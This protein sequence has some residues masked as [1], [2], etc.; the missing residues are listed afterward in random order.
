MPERYFELDVATEAYIHSYKKTR[1]VITIQ[2]GKYAAHITEHYDNDETVIVFCTW[3][4][5]I[6]LPPVVVGTYY[7]KTPLMQKMRLIEVK[8]EKKD[9]FVECG[10][11]KEK[12]GMSF[13]EFGK[14]TFVPANKMN[15]VYR[16][17]LCKEVA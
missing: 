11:C 7:G 9:L 10:F 17:E 15:Y 2:P 14:I 1:D 5:S 16:C 12:S 4:K 8:E 3:V 13:D 6:H